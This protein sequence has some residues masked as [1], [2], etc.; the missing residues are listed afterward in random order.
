MPLLTSTDVPSAPTSQSR[1]ATAAAS[2][3]SPSKE[4]VSENVGMPRM[5]VSSASGWLVKLTEQASSR[6][7]GP[8]MAGVSPPAS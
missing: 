6:F 2:T 3:A 5:K 7:C 8:G 4:Q 1:A